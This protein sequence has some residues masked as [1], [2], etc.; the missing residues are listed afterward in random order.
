MGG[1]AEAA[2]VMQRRS[3]NEGGLAEAACVLQR[4]S[5]NVGGPSY[6]ILGSARTQPNSTQL[7]PTQHNP[8]HFYSTQ[9]NQQPATSTPRDVVH[10]LFV[11]TPRC[12]PHR[13]MGQPRDV[14]HTLFVRTPRCRPRRLLGE[15]ENTALKPKKGTRPGTRREMRNRRQDFRGSQDAEYQL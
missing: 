12:R 6:G 8:T 7:N 5:P 10:T 3:P 13:L 14:V 15:G 9:L 11:R 4:R 1:Q 2:C